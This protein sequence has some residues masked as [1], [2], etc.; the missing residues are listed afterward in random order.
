MLETMR[1]LRVTFGVAVTVCAFA[2]TAMPALATEVEA[3]KEGYTHGTSETEQT[4]K[5]GEIEITCFKVSAKGAVT[6][7]VNS[8]YTTSIKFNKCLT[9]AR[10]GI[11]TFYLRT[12]FLTPLVISYQPNG[13][14]VSGTT[15]EIK[16]KTGTTEEFEP[17]ECEIYIPEQTVPSKAINKPNETYFMFSMTEGV[18]LGHKVSPTFPDG[19]QHTIEI[20]NTI[21]GFKYELEGEPCEEWAK[22]EGPEGIGGQYFGSFPQILGGGNLYIK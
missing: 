2:L 20:N 14:I 6:A 12:K 11:H 17:S 7:G 3:S 13:S 18:P 4:L 21:K 9:K 16:F 5:F 1:H 8:T 10:L 15:A 22:E 19:L